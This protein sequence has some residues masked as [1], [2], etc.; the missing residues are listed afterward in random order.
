MPGEASK[1]IAPCSRKPRTFKR[2]GAVGTTLLEL[3]V[4]VAIVSVLLA[5]SVPGY[6]SSMKSMHLSSATTAISGAIQSTRFT[7]PS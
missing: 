3:V 5:I 6:Q 2:S 4:V 7:R 1:H